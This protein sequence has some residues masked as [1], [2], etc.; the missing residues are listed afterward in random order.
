MDFSMAHKDFSAIFT[1]IED[2][3]LKINYLH[4]LGEHSPPALRTT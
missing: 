4:G 1:L 2:L 3:R